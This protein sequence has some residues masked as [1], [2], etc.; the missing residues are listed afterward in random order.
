MWLQKPKTFERIRIY[1]EVLK[2][3]VSGLRLIIQSKSAKFVKDSS[4]VAELEQ[5][6]AFMRCDVTE[7]HSPIEVKG[8]CEKYGEA[9]T[10][11][12]LRF[13][14]S[15]GRGKYVLI[16]D[17]C[18]DRYEEVGLGALFLRGLRWVYESRSFYSPIK[19]EDKVFVVECKKVESWIV[20]PFGGIF[21]Q[22]KPKRDPLRF[23]WMTE[24]AITILQTEYGVPEAGPVGRPA[25]QWESEGEFG[26]GA[27]STMSRVECSFAAGSPLILAF[28]VAG[29]AGFVISIV[30][31]LMMI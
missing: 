3:E 26:F 14:E 8:S 4:H 31:L 29:I 12:V 25:F 21:W 24:V 9:D 18:T 5:E 13:P 1:L 27:P 17:L 22:I 2:G 19:E 6:K 23:N 20:P 30:N 11:V 16:F 7:K 15:R 28:G 10:E